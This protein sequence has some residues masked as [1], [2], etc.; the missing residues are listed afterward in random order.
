MS[1]GMFCAV[2]LPFRA[3]DDRAK[4][5]MLPCLP[6][7]GAFIGALWW[8]IAELLM[9]CGINTMLIAGVVAVVPFIASGFLHLD[10]YMDTSDAL[11]S[12]RTIEE[13]QRILKDPHVGS[14]AA[15][16]LAILFVMQFTTVFSVIEKGAGLALL[17]IIPITSRCCSA[18]SVLCLKPMNQSGYANMFRQGAS[19]SHKVFI[20]LIVIFAIAASYFFAKSCGLIVVASSA[21]GFTVAMAWAYQDMKGMSGDLAGFALVIGEL[22]GLVALALMAA[23]SDIFT[24]P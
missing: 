19:L 15:V 24:Q 3:W 2:P 22:C 8:G 23:P 13:K 16:M 12:C 11:L 7:V 14:F 21:A 10:G 17:I 5:L 9:L 6:L 1:F 18:L 20:V 4:N